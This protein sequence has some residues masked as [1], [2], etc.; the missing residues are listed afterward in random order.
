MRGLRFRLSLKKW[1]ARKASG[2]ER[3]P[4]DSAEPIAYTKTSRI[5]M[6]CWLI[7][8]R[9]RMF[10]TLWLDYN[11]ERRVIGTRVVWNNRSTL[12]VV[13]VFALWNRIE[14]EDLDQ[15]ISEVIGTFDGVEE[16]SVGLRE[17]IAI[18]FKGSIGYGKSLLFQLLPGICSVFKWA[19]GRLR[20]SKCALFLLLF[21]YWEVVTRIL[22]FCGLFLAGMIFSL[23]RIE[24]IFFNLFWN[25]NFS[26]AA[27]KNFCPS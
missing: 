15:A 2:Q 21:S 11:H 8:W 12:H 17:D 7:P 22:I 27:K 1:P 4:F 14:T 23:M 20:L 26:V 13:F 6:F 24:S 18:I 9:Y 19:A 10:Q 5:W 16:I 25:V 3:H